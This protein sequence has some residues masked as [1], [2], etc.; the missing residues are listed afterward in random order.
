MHK[1]G[2]LEGH[3]F[4]AALLSVGFSLCG[5]PSLAQATA[6]PRSFS[7]PRIVPESFSWHLG[8]GGTKDV[9]VQ[10]IGVSGSPLYLIECHPPDFQQDDF[11]YSGVYQCR[12]ESQLAF[13]PGQDL[14]TEGA[15]TER[16][17]QSIA[18]FS[19]SDLGSGS[20][21]RRA[22]IRGMDI[23]FGIRNAR[24]NADA[25]SAF[26][27]WLDV[28]PDPGAWAATCCAGLPQMSSSRRKWP[29]IRR[30]QGHLSLSE[31]SQRLG[32][33]TASGV[34][35]LGD[36]SEG[37]LKLPVLQANGVPLYTLRCA[38]FSDFAARDSAGHPRLGVGCGLYTPAGVNL[39]LPARDPVSLLNPEYVLPE[40]LTPECRTYPGW[41]ATREFLLRGMDL[42][43]TLRHVR[44][45]T[46]QL[47]G[48][49]VHLVFPPLLTQA[50]LEVEVRADPTATRALPAPPDSVYWNVLPSDNPCS[51]VLYRSEPEAA[52]SSGPAE[53]WSK[54][55][56]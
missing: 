43:M 42:T 14:F 18:L 33:V 2:W 22:R 29:E 3:L 49:G 11:S 50:D 25:L 24:G 54:N 35:Q 8:P 1:R 19:R 31:S 48:V 45:R 6:P 4:K 52:T 30:T 34:W 12:L 39:L 23:S 55:D 40:Q 17:Y 32:A 38:A 51:H 28:Q 7:W 53:R 16:D 44:L 20:A 46:D 13:L 27:F 21:A 10:I 5:A 15:F 26:D 41:G 56:K 9:R 36:H 47:D 37:I